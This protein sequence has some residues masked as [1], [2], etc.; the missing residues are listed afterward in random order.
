MSFEAV[1]GALV[2]AGATLAATWFTL[3]KSSQDEQRR[4]ERERESRDR[5]ARRPVYAAVLRTMTVWREAC[6]ELIGVETS[7]D[8]QW[9][10]Y[11]SARQDC[12]EA[13]TELELLAPAEVMSPAFEAVEVL[14]DLSW[15]F[16]NNGP[17]F[18]SSKSVWGRLG[19][20]DKYM[21]EFRDLAR[22]EFGIPPLG[23]EWPDGSIDEMRARAN[24]PPAA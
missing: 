22:A 5:E 20:V 13:G 19:V 6:V 8:E 10:A 16:D 17:E 2:G 15:D 1:L 9:A 18:A 12:L 14:L 23:R 7:E 11:W 3:R 21:E 4:W 24:R